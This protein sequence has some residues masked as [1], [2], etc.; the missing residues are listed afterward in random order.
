[1]NVKRYCVDTNI[2]IYS[3]DN[4]AGNHHKSAATLMQKMMVSDCVLTLQ[5]LCEFFHASTRK[6]NMPK[7]DARSQNLTRW[8]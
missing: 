7:S 6:G 8:L 3:I 5:S 4:K 2:L 1:M